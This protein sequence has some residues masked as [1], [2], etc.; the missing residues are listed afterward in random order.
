MARPLAV[1]QGG[2][3]RHLAGDLG[4]AAFPPLAKHRAWAGV[5][6][7]GEPQPTFRSLGL[8]SSRGHRF[9]VSVT[10]WVWAWGCASGHCGVGMG[11]RVMGVGMEFGHV[12]VMGLVIG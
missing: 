8:G 2:L 10:I 3:H 4:A 12:R 5:H 6:E 9:K 7:A 1:L 11:M